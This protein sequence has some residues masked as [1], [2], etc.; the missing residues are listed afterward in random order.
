MAH[1]GRVSDPRPTGRANR[2]LR[3]NVGDMLRSMAVVLVV[4]AAIMVVTWR[5]QPDPVRTV[6]LEPSATLAT[7]QADFPVFIVNPSLGGQVTSVRWESTPDSDGELVW[8]VGYVT[9]DGEYLQLSQSAAESPAYL[10][11]QTYA[12]QAL[13]DF[14]DLPGSVQ[15]LT[16]QGWMPWAGDDRRSLVRM[17]DGSTTVLSGTASWAELGDAAQNLTLP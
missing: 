17:N 7:T 1:D 6:S 5:P 12:G 11:E 13:P 8:H 3:Q 4:V 14:S 2:G 16:S 15:S 10:S 9:E